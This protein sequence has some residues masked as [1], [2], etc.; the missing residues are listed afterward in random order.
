MM[1]MFG[2]LVSVGLLVDGSIVMVEY[3]DRKIMKASTERLLTLKPTKEYGYYFTMHT[4]QHFYLV[5][6][7]GIPGQFM[8]WM[9]FMVSPVLVSSLLSA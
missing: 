9:P 5:L 3:A 4:L 7:P 2:L 8:K 6:W 1:V